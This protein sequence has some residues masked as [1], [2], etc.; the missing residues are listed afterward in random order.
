MARRVER[1][2]LCYLADGTPLWPGDRLA[3]VQA[4]QWMFF[5]RYSHEPYIAVARFVRLFLKKPDDPRPPELDKRGH[6]ALGVME[7]HLARNDDFVTGRL[8]IADIALFAYTHCAGEAGFDLG[9]YSAVRAWIDPCLAQPG[10]TAMSSPRSR[11]RA[12][13]P[14][15]RPG[16]TAICPPS[17][18]PTARA[19][20]IAG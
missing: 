14:A 10:V 12:A 3:R 2:I 9:G 7:G 15:F 8:T 19:A 13:H 1:A 20:S 18:G 11:W 16:S 17:R 6:Q 4:L 5:E